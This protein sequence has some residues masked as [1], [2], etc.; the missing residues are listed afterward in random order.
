MFQLFY[1]GLNWQI[2][3]WGLI[4]GKIKNFWS[5]I[6]LLK[7]QIFQKMGKN[8]LYSDFEIPNSA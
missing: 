1:Q 8:L 2:A 7:V 4:S 5:R 3:T 6:G